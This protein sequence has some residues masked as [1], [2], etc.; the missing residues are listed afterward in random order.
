[1]SRIIVTGPCLLVFALAGSAFAQ[2]LY[3]Y[4]TQGQSQDQ[5]NQDRYQCHTWAVQQTGFDPTQPQ[6]AYNA[7]PPQQEA[8]QGGLLRGAGRGAAIGAIGGAIGGNAGKGAAIGAGAGALIGG[9]RRRDQRRRQEQ[10]QRQY[11]QQ[12]QQQQAA[13]NQQQSNYNRA[14]SVCLNGRGYQVR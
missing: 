13:V 5:L 4:P 2:Q 9:M 14:L 3:V 11:Q 8:Q 10:Q 7:P 12:Q 6:T 1:M